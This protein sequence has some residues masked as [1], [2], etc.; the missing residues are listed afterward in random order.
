MGCHIGRACY[1]KWASQVT[2][3]DVFINTKAN[4]VTTLGDKVAITL[5]ECATT[6]RRASLPPW[7]TL[8][9]QRP[10]M[11][12]H[13]ATPHRIGQVHIVAPSQR[14]LSTQ[15]LTLTLHWATMVPYWTIKLP[16]EIKVVAPWPNLITLMGNDGILDS[17]GCYVLH[18]VAPNKE[19]FVF[20]LANSVTERYYCG[21]SCCGM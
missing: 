9:T 6:K 13:W 20:A 5:D 12:P 10:T 14:T 16:C 19:D 11:L 7:R 1:H 2:P 17:L 8:S 18:D 3:K 15:R 21:G 4:S